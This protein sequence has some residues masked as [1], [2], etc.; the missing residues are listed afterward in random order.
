MNIVTRSIL[1]TVRSVLWFYR[2]ASAHIVENLVPV[3]NSE[4]PH[5]SIKFWCTGYIP[6]MRAQTLL[7]KEP[8]TIRRMDSFQPHSVF[9]DIGANVGV[10]SLYAA[11]RGNL[12][13]LTFEPSAFNYHLLARNVVLNAF[14]HAVRPLCVAFADRTCL[15][16]FYLHSALAGDAFHSFSDS[17]GFDGQA[18]EARVSHGMIAYSI[19]DFVA[20]FHPP[21]PNYVKI[22][23]DGLEDRILR[24]ARNTLS[25]ARLCSLQ[26][27]PDTEE[28]LTSSVID[29]L[30]SCGL[31]LDKHYGAF[32]DSVYN[33]IFSL[34]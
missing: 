4:T 23:V 11:A 12:E 19:D 30:R 2:H 26:V 1:R 17:K 16:T 3:V 28:A 6:L 33:H 10:Y 25:D 31:T 5:G 14:E 9:W 15:D 24:G 21:F 32:T 29:M 18:A 13:V 8:G 20:T 7:S 34:L 27:E 22:D